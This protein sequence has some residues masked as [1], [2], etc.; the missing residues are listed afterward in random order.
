M[1][2]SF[3]ILLFLIGIANGFYSGLMGTGGNVI[4]IPALDLILSHYGIP[5][6]EIV[7]FI[8]AHSLFITFFN[9]LFVSYKQYKINNFYYKEVLLIAFPAMVSGFIMSEIIKISSWYDKIYFDLIFLFL[10]VLIATRFLFFKEKVINKVETN[11]VTIKKAF[12]FGLGTLTGLTTA[13][14]G[15]GGGIVLIPALTEFCKISIKKASSISIGVV[16]FLAISI[17][18]SYL[19]IGA[20]NNIK[21]L[22]PNQLGYISISLITPVLFGVFIAAP[23]GVKVAQKTAPSILRYLFGSVMVLI[24]LKTVVSLLS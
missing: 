7:K 10:V 5:E 16:M 12:S 15:F 17:S 14:S 1:A 23:F 11:K 9:G 3:I 20:T 2:I 8:I 13:L 22:L 6:S 4:L 18:I 21:S 24:C 19:N